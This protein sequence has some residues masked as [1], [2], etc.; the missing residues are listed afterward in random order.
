MIKKAP[1]DA[2]LWFFL[3]LFF[4]SIFMLGRLLWPFVSIIVLAAVV[5]GI[6]SPVYNFV[7]I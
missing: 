1:Q 7:K 5:T 6:F 2:I 4:V 3:A